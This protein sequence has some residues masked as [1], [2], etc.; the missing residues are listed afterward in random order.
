MDT[1][2]CFDDMCPIPQLKAKRKYEE[3]AKGESFKLVTDHSCAVENIKHLFEGKNNII[4]KCLEVIDGV[5]EVY[6]TKL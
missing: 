4:F 1:L 6:I 5:W 2:E 3:L